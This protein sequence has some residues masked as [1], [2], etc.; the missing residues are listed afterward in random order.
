MKREA[1]IRRRNKGRK[2]ILKKNK[3]AKKGWF[4]EP[5]DYF[6]WSPLPGIELSTTS[7]IC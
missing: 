5:V 4:F 3:K 6:R 7:P 2:E 1:A